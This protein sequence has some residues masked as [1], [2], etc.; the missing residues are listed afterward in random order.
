M[1]T[2]Q[3]GDIVLEPFPFTDL[4]R[5]KVRPAVVV[6]PSSFNRTSLDIMLAAISSRIPPTSADTEL[7]IRQG[8]ADFRTTGLRVSSVIRATKLITM[9]QTLISAT[10]GRLSN[11]HIDELDIRLA[12]AIGLPTLREAIAARQAA[13]ARIATLT[14][15]VR[16]LEQQLAAG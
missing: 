9:Q 14:I 11:H 2:F 1:M 5:P 8:S 10:L 15:R 4:T 13:E 7:I 3:R 12:R 16:D 6:S